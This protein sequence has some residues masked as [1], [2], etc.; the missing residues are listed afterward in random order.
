MA[1]HQHNLACA[2]SDKAQRDVVGKRNERRPTQVGG[3]RQV[4]TTVA[5][6]L[7]AEAVVDKGGHNAV[8]LSPGCG[9][10]RFSG[11][12]GHGFGE[13]RVNTHG[14]V[15][16]VL[17]KCADGDEEYGIACEFV[18]IREGVHL[19]HVD[20]RFHGESLPSTGQRCSRP[21]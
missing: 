11:F 2:L 18:T 12:A 19:F 16:T 17:L 21:V 14:H 20:S 3:S 6:L 7:R 9:L 15:R 4:E 10:K 1:V 5:A 13:R 8:D